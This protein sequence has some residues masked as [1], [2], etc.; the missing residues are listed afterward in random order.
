MKSMTFLKILTIVGATFFS[1]P[2][3]YAQSTSADFSDGS[4]IMDSQTTGTCDSTT[5]GAMRYTA[6]N[7]IEH[8]NGTNWVIG[9]TGASAGA[10]TGSLSVS[11][12]FTDGSVRIGNDNR[13]C[14]GALEG[15]LRYNPTAAVPSAAPSSGLVGYWPLDESS[16][17]HVADHSGNGL[18]G[19][20]MGDYTW[21]DT[22]GQVGG[23]WEANDVS[24]FRLMQFPINSIM[25]DIND[26]VTV[27]FW[28]KD[29][30]SA[31]D[32]H[33]FLNKQ[34]GGSGWRFQGTPT[35][36]AYCRLRTDT[37]GG[38]NQTLDTCDDTLDGSWH[39]YAV[40]LDSGARDVYED[41]TLHEGYSY[42]H[43]AGFASLSPM[44]LGGDTT[45]GV[46]DEVYV[47]DRALNSTEI[48]D[49][50]G[51]ASP[52]SGGSDFQYCDG[53]DWVAM[54]ASGSITPSYDLTDGLASHWKLDETSGTTAT[55]SAGTD[56]GTM[57]GG[58]SGAD[59]TA[60]QDGTSLFFERDDDVYIQTTNTTVETEDD[61]T[62]S[63]WFRTTYVSA[64]NEE[65]VILWQ[66]DSA[67]NGGGAQYEFTLNIGNVTDSDDQKIQFHV[68]QNGASGVD[69]ADI[70][71]LTDFN[72]PNVWHHLAI[73][74]T[75]MSTAEPKAHMFLDTNWTG[76]DTA[77][78]AIPRGTWN[79][80]LRIGGEPSL[81]RMFD[82]EIDDV[83][84][85]DKALNVGE[86]R[87]I[88]LDTGGT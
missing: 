34:Y 22:G 17:T 5:E 76:V 33:N 16:G 3:A 11:G 54:S 67:G 1:S 77:G 21:D 68:E 52:A 47:Y 29:I 61:F 39:H 82:G 43:G 60:G 66:G 48:N 23:A 88:Y 72:D 38:L 13:A 83:R 9:E 57:T 37:S 53:T 65:Q 2:Q 58:L 24:S 4:V 71:L 44:E 6:T 55:D 87:Q 7:G 46:F 50:Y 42:P 25:D 59:S 63:L 70:N 26:A 51:I 85:Y 12:D 75:G 74:V 18:H 35:V 79:E 27:L 30:G 73:V 20:A 40:V 8:C 56:D 49:I 36:S 31:D 15:A 62:L 84:V 78:G 81:T 28:Y 32:Y 86:I 41:G 14:S 19:V 64:G 45:Y 69:D 10:G 80:D